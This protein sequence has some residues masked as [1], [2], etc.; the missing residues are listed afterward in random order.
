VTEFPGWGLGAGIVQ[1]I[2]TLCGLD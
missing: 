1:N 2:F